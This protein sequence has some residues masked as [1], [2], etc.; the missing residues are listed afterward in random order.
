[1]NAMESI[2]GIFGSRFEFN[3]RPREGKIDQSGLGRF[4]RLLVDLPDVQNFSEVSAT[5][6]LGMMVDRHND[7]DFVVLDVRTATEYNTLHILGAINRDYYADDFAAQLKA[8]DKNKAY[9]IHCRTGGR[10]QCHVGWPRT[11]DHADHQTLHTVN[12]Q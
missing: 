9:L 2:I 1:M 10:S 3:F 12:D 4:Y 6:A 11:Y 5:A 7:S 8:L